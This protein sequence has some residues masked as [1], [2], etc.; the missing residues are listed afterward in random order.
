MGNLLFSG[1]E[2]DEALRSTKAALVRD[3]EK[4][5]PDELLTQSES[6]IAA[7]LADKHSV[8]APVLRRDAIYADEPRDGKRSI[9]DDFFGRDVEV[10]VSTLRIH[11][12]Y[13]GEK[14]FFSL[15]PNQFTFNPPRARVGADVLTF[16]FEDR[17]LNGEKIKAALDRQLDSIDKYLAASRQMAEQHNESILNAALSAIQ[18]RKERLLADRATV[19]GLGIPVRRRGDPPAVAVPVKTRPPRIERPRSALGPYEPEWVLSES[20]YEEAVRIII[21]AGVQMERSP[22]TTL[23]LDEEE[24]R[25]LILIALNAVFEGQ[26]GGEVFNGS[27]KTD[28]LLR[29]ENRNVFIAECKI[30]RGQKGFGAAIDQLLGYLVW[31]DTKAALVLFIETRKATQTVRRALDVL[32]EHPNC[33]RTVASSEDAGRS[34]FIFKST[35]DDAREI[36]LAFIPVVVASP[37]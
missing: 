23:Q 13:D 2:L 24:R 25:D 31:R 5:D 11:V 4:W 36:R 8:R 10:S 22:S 6:E 1:G 32:K 14:V 30:W 28:I 35:G 33:V 3:V 19:A 7:F 26:A 15:R 17:E 21:N 37:E 29:V 12:P 34:D 20:D 9:S 16:E 27:G 18:A